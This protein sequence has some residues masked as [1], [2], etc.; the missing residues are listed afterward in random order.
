MQ[1]REF[2]TLGASAVTC[3]LSRPLAAKAQQANERRILQS[4]ILRLQAEAVA[5]RIAEFI[6]GIE[7]QLAWTTQ[8]PLS[9]GTLDDRRF[10]AV[11]LLRLVPA[12]TVIAQ[13]DGTGKEQL[14]I[15]RSS[16]DAVNTE[17]DFSQD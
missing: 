11:R 16:M 4:R 7:S 14:R 17:T 6:S 8:L 13:L 10:E 15:S 1:R 2:M 9:A 12:I 3:V 5:G